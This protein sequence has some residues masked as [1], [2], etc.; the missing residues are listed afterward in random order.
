VKLQQA[1]A[2]ES[3]AIGGFKLIGYEAPGANGVTTNF[4]YTGAVDATATTTD[5]TPDAWKAEANVALNDCPKTST[6]DIKA[7]IASTT[8]VV[9]FDATLGDETN[10]L[11][12]TPNF[13]LIGK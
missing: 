5:E 1:Y 11:T 2:S 7:T 12:L 8:S 10:C 6:W 13:K 4:T 9:S 3:N